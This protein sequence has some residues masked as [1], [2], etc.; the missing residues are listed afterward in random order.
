M[1]GVSWLR[2]SMTRR[3]KYEYHDAGVTGVRIG[4]RREVTLTAKLDHVV[5]GRDAVVNLRFGGIANFSQVEKYFGGVVADV[6][7]SYL[8]R[9]D[10]L[11]YDESVPTTSSDL[12][13]RLE[14]DGCG[15][16][17]IRCRNVTEEE[18]GGDGGSYLI[19][20]AS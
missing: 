20:T 18:I 11:G 16:V 15:G 5:A 10:E 4:P 9:I 6:G 2:M 1:R 17:Q 14:V 13:L 12:A 8:S 7:E 19:K 3:L